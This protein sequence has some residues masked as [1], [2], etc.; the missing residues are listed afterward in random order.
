MAEPM[1]DAQLAEILDGCVD[2]QDVV[3]VLPA[4]VQRLRAEADLVA[5][6]REYVT[7]LWRGAVGLLGC[8]TLSTIF[9]F[10]FGSLLKHFWGWP[11]YWVSC[12]GAGMAAG[13]CIAQI[14]DWWKN[15][16]G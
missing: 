8:F 12:A 5:A 1:S 11:A 13:W 14:E 9:W 7:K 10:S 16:H 15:R 4:E 6:T 3:V 2:D